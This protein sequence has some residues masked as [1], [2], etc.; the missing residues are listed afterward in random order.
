MW[1]DLYWQHGSTVVKP[2]CERQW[3]AAAARLILGSAAAAG[4][5]GECSSRVGVADSSA[6]TTAPNAGRGQGLA[7][8]AS[9]NPIMPVND[10]SQWQA[11]THVLGQRQGLWGGIGAVGWWSDV[12]WWLDLCWQYAAP[13]STPFGRV[14][15]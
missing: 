14:S 15:E 2:W 9:Q 11:M 8:I 13:L 12:V 7:G 3:A 5:Y 10:S 1:S 4:R 6:G